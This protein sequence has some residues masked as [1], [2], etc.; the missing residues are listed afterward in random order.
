MRFLE[1]D[2]H[3]FYKHCGTAMF[4]G[5]SANRASLSIEYCFEQ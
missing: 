2:F 5:G 4:E 3:I 1:D